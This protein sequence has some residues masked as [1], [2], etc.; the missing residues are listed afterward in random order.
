MN[1]LMPIMHD[2][3]AAM[4][5]GGLRP[6][7]TERV[8]LRE[9]IG[10]M[11]RRAW[12]ALGVAVVLFAVVLAVVMNIT[13]KYTASGSVLIDPHHQN[14]TQAEPLQ[15][16]L[17]PDTSAVDTQVEVLRSR[18]LAEAVV[19]KMALYNDPEF[20][21]DL[22]GKRGAITN[23]S[24]Q[25]VGRVTEAVQGRTQVKRQGLT[26]VIQVS[27]TSKS[28]ARAAA[29]VNTF[30]TTYMQR[31]LDAKSAAIIKA[32]NDLGPNIERLRADA[33]AA[34][35][36]VQEYKAAHNLMTVDAG[37]TMAAQEISTLNEQIAKAKADTAERQARLETALAQVRNG[38][39]G[40]DVGAALGSQ[41]I[42]DLRK[43]EA[44]LSTRLAQLKTDF[45][46]GYP[47][48]QRTQNE[49]NDVRS[50]IQQEINR[51]ISNLKAEAAA[52]A[53]RERSLLASRSASQGGLM[54]NTQAQVGLFGL[55]QRADAAKQIYEGYLNR[56]KQVAAESGLQQPDA[57]V[58]SAAAA[59]LHP[60]SPN[61]RVAMA[62]AAVLALIGGALSVLIAEMWDNSLRS[63]QDVE[64]ELGLPLAGAL[65]DFAS[66]RGRKSRHAKPSDYL[67]SHP[68][69]SFAEAYRNVRAFMLL[70]SPDRSAKTIAVTSSV[71]REGKSLTSLCLARTLAMAG[72]RV[73][74]VDCDMRQ[75]GVTKLVGDTDIG[76]AEVI[77]GKNTLSEAMVPDAKSSAWILPSTSATSP[78][79]HDIFGRPNVDEIFQELRD[80]FDYVILDTP[81]VLGVA[82][83]RVVSARADQVLYV[84]RWSKTPRRAA[85][86]GLDILQES[87][88]NVAG[89]LLSRVNVKKQAAYGYGDSSDYFHYFRNYYIANA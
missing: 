12:L 14:L 68:L 10:T 46:D 87:G 88:A 43:R 58:N 4:G 81:P 2:L 67:V 19:R 72:S 18:A 25:L 83:A 44:D 35:A 7:E 54:A 28:P 47:D 70:A 42:N 17:P 71:P 85:Q 33:E 49:L 76:L 21:A 84:V 78:E 22:H 89:V 60:S 11:L 38:S 66:V 1:S 27:F 77:E 86:S 36:K 74:L 51:V 61:L 75:R 80:S 55:Q 53:Q 73:V 59:P 30:M 13:P 79:H 5:A 82:D 3:P 65:P 39:G 69:S 9:L 41:T 8:D 57:T 63:R 52:A 45:K 62:A 24:P 56:A 15:G 23:P 6:Y 20:N 40:Q 48:V 64:R 29:I 32:N 31:Q 37:Q 34:Q 50:Q 26:Y 16:G